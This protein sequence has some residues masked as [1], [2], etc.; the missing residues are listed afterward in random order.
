MHKKL[1][2]CLLIKLYSFTILAQYKVIY[3]AN[4]VFDTSSVKH[5]TELTT[6]YINENKTSYFFSQNFQKSDSVRKQILIQHAQ[7]TAKEFS[8]QS[9]SLP[10]TEFKF[11][12]EKKY[13]SQELKVFKHIHIS[14]YTYSVKNSLD[15]QLYPDT[16]KIKNYICNKA[17]VKLEGRNYVAW[18]T[19]EIPISD[20]PY[21]FWGL[22]G[23]I[24]KVTDTENHYEF[25]L[26]SFEKYSGNP[27]KRPYQDQKT[28][29]VSYEDYIVISKEAIEK[30]L[31]A[32]NRQGSSKLISVNGQDPSTFTSKKKQNPIEKY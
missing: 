20:G 1:T 30:P 23:L 25:S 26:E 22:P 4:Y 31:L 28:F 21:K 2:F 15:W 32:R 18:Y 8:Y 24:L 6:L 12:I 7:N 13:S 10:K 29:D 17:T 27:P 14:N 3:R 11:F 5:R 19:P 9:G 16:L